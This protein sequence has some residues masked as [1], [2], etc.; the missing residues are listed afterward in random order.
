MTRETEGVKS[1]G[2]SKT[3]SIRLKIAVVAPT[4]MARTAA[5]LI[6]IKRVPRK[7]RTAYLKS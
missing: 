1:R 5:P 3:E 4:P 6:Q 2:R 7:L